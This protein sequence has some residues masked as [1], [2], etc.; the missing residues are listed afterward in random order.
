MAH[1]VSDRVRAYRQRRKATSNV[2]RCEV[3]VH[4]DDAA[5]V[6]AY[7]AQLTEWRR[8]GAWHELQRE[9]AMAFLRAGGSVAAL[10]ARNG[11]LALPDAEVEIKDFEDE[12]W[13]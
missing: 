11:M 13:I 3:A 6:R 10:N 4:A 2:I 12:Q 5:L 9:A 7:A 8:T 1:P